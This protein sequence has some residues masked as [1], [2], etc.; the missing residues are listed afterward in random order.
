METKRRFK[1]VGTEQNAKDYD[2]SGNNR[3]EVGKIYD[4]MVVFSG[5]S[6]GSWAT[7]N[8]IKHEWQEVFDEDL[9]QKD[10]LSMSGICGGVTFS[11][12]GDFVK[13]SQVLNFIFNLDAR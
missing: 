4:E 11:V 10:I 3:P 9:H 5:E 2:T 6:V 1:F 8:A 12:S 7:D 13:C